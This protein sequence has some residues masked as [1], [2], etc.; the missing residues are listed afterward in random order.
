MAIS[1]T[2]G[3]ATPEPQASGSLRDVEKRRRQ[4]FKP[5]LD[6]PFTQGHQWPAVEPELGASMV[7]VLALVLSNLGS[8][9]LIVKE[10]RSKKGTQPLKL[11][12]EPA[13]LKHITIGFNSTVQRLEK[14]ASHKRAKVGNKKIKADDSD[15]SYI[16]YVFVAK[17][18]ISPPILTQHFPLLSFTASKSRQERVK[19]V[20]LPRGATKKLSETLGIP[21]TTIIG[22]TGDIREAKPLYALADKVENVEAP[23][24]EGLFGGADEVYF[25]KPALRVLATTAPMGKKAEGKEKGKQKSKGGKRKGEEEKEK[26]HEK[27]ENK[28]K[29]NV[30][31]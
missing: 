16:K 14:Q 9:N 23:W 3:S 4:V 15:S 5:V 29:A 28:E 19:L 10:M 26:K 8:Y 25:H 2:T 30:K 18:E 11:P 22:L 1:E 27:D 6:N 21:N 17:A 12:T 20:Q 31:K 13:I 7:D 24:L